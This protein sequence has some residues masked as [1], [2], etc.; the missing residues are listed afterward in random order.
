M[1]TFDLFRSPFAMSGDKM[2]LLKDKFSP[3]KVGDGTRQLQWL[4]CV[5]QPNKCV[6][7]DGGIKH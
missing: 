3:S 5:Q 6:F 4:Y 1:S 7:E 2:A